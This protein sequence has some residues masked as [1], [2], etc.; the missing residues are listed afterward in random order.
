M[1]K[2][3]ENRDYAGIFICCA[4]AAVLI[5]FCLLVFGIWKEYKD[6]IINN[7]KKQMLLTTQSMGEN[8]KVFIEGYQSDLSTIYDIMEENYK[9][10]GTNWKYDISVLAMGFNIIVHQIHHLKIIN[11][12]YF[13]KS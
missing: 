7:Q 10:T 2:I 5:I 1:K 8:L 13:F 6:A 3:K 11:E 4:M 12:K 9:K